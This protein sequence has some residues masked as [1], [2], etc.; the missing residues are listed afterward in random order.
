ALEHS[1]K[2]EKRSTAAKVMILGGCIAAV[3]AVGGGYVMNRQ[4]E[5][6]REAQKELDLAALYESGSVK[7][8]GTAG[9]L[10]HTP[11]AGGA[12]KSGGGAG[13]GGFSSYEDAM[14]QAMELGDASKGGGER[15]LSSADVA[16]VM[17]RNLNSMFSCVSE[18]LRRGGKLGKVVIDLAIMGSGHVAGASVNTG[19]PGFQRCMSAK[20]QHVSFPS[21]PAPRM[22][23]RYS[24]NVD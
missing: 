17:N 5:K 14:N 11:R 1:T 16:G 23:A 12:R 8:T 9:I 15:Q 4:Q 18:E 20:V 10:Q 7:V 3:L 6:K 19:S 24:F 21:F 2:V 22:G 13:P